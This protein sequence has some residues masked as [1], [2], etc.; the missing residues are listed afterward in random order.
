M[1]KLLSLALLFP[2]SVICLY[3]QASSNVLSRLGMSSQYGAKHFSGN[4]FISPLQKSKLEK[5][6]LTPR[7]IDALFTPSSHEI[8]T[9]LK[10]STIGFAGVIYCLDTTLVDLRQLYGYSYAILSGEIGQD[11]PT[12]KQILNIIG[13]PF[14]AAVISLGWPISPSRLLEIEIQFHAILEKVIDIMPLQA[15][16]GATE[17]LN[18][19]IETS[20][21]VSVL[22]QSLPRSLALKILKK[23][24]LS[25]IFEGRVPPEHLLCRDIPTKEEYNRLSLSER[26][27]NDDDD[28][29]GVTTSS[30]GISN[31]LYHEAF[32]TQQI[33]RA[34]G[35][36]R[37]CSM[38]TVY[39]DGCAKNV[40]AAKRAGLGVVAL[41]GFAENA[42]ELKAADKVVPS[43]EYVTAGPL[44]KVCRQ[45]TIRRI[46]RMR[47]CVSV[48]LYRCC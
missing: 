14:K 35:V 11:T 42:F 37:T 19:V 44:Y 36:M 10:S 46:L 28:S 3:I 12:P 31:Q 23:T 43:L 32:P 22:S 17:S 25:A 13:L 41:S 29:D 18:S 38:L 5:G 47:V 21:Q 8:D 2:C 40:M 24:S 9:I 34:N 16:A 6:L 30:S 1:R 33:V 4:H 15:S 20:N 48:C 27:G 45:S 26:N 39:I 7:E